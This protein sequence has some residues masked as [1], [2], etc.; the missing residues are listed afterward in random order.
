MDISDQLNICTPLKPPFTDKYTSYEERE[1]YLLDYLKNTLPSCDVG[2]IENEL[3]KT[4]QFV[5]HKSRVTKTKPK[6]VPFLTA[7]KSILLSLNKFGKKDLKY[8]DM[9][10]LNSM[11]LN[12]MY[13][14]LGI[15]NYKDL[16]T[17][18]ID[19]RWE[20]VNQKLIKADYHGAVVTI[21]RSRSSNTVG[22]KGIIIQDTKNTLRLL[23]KDNVIRMIP[24]ESCVFLIHLENN[25]KVQVFGKELCVR[26]AERSVK[27]FKNLPIPEL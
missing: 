5:K 17:N 12:Y 18:P 26:P 25:V 27:K 7:R 8:R 4:F 23:S 21:T 6:K 10:P 24:K 3:K 11:W 1:Q 14:M 22:T 2:G 15:R 16:P 19:S 13:P 20:T 9:L